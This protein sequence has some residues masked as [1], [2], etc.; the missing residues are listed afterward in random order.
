LHAP[1]AASYE[2]SP[3]KLVKFLSWISLFLILGS[4]MFLSI[5][6]ANYARQTLLK[7]QQE[8]ALL[9]AENLN[10]Q[11][12]QRFTLPTI[13]RFRRIELQNE[14]QYEQM[15]KV[16]RSTIHG[17]HVMELRVYDFDRVISFSLDKEVVGRDDLAGNAVR[18]SLRDERHGF[19]TIS[20]APP[21]WAM[22][23]LDMEPES[24]VMR[25]V[26]PLR[27]ER[28]LIPGGPSGQVMGI[29]EFTQDITE[30]Y[31]TVINFQWLVIATSLVSSLF[32]FF[33]L[34][35]FV[36]MAA[37]TLA[38]RALEKQKLERELLQSE[39]L[40]GMGRMVAGIA[41]E[42]RN[43][44]G[45][46]QSSAEL[47]L[48]KAEAEESPH[49]RIL[50]AMFDEAKRLGRT[51]NE[52]L[53]YARPKQPRRDHVDL[54]EVLDQVL[55]F[56]ERECADKGVKVAG[57]YAQGLHVRGD[58]D[59]LYRAFYNILVNSLQ[60][61]DGAGEIS[62]A[63]EVL[64]G[65]IAVIFQ[66][67]GQGFDPDALDKLADPFFTTRDQGTGLG[68]A[69]AANIIESHEGRLGFSNAPEGG[70]RVRVVFPK[71]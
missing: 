18:Q 71:A 54:G 58:K 53:D 60:A 26:Y 69:I 43:P 62:V 1:K 47:L 34:L 48:K 24:V 28:S 63:G 29:L 51:V 10:H 8:F 19:E 31:G 46:I 9:L 68:L 20:R 35:V 15:D 59:L 17:Q 65:R 2:T 56:L 67:S 57:D 52:F 55:G 64:K 39:K 22:F 36:R 32:L 4:G 30:D 23:D 11:I 33:I 13:L 70:A 44:L 41:H 3:F 6:I 21:F 7:K 66:D 42:I 40:A 45:V 61:M 14:E 50:R 5:V 25:T 37:R 38:E 49:T 16:V 27:A 12:F